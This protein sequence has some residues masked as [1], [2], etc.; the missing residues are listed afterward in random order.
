M[1]SVITFEFKEIGLT[2]VKLFIILFGS[3]YGFVGS[4]SQLIDTH[5]M[6]RVM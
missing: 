3:A 5:F 1:I 4:L 6:L 2:Y